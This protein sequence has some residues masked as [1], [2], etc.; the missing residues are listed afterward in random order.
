[1]QNHWKSTWNCA[2]ALS[3]RE[4]EQLERGYHAMPASRPNSD[5]SDLPTFRSSGAV[6]E[7]GEIEYA[8]TAQ[9]R[10]KIRHGGMVV[11][12]WLCQ[13]L[14]LIHSNRRNLMKFVYLIFRT[15]PTSRKLSCFQ[16][17]LTNLDDPNPQSPG[18]TRQRTRTVAPRIGAMPKA[19]PSPTT[20]PG[21]NLKPNISKRFSHRHDYSTFLKQDAGKGRNS[22]FIPFCCHYHKT[23]EV[24]LFKT[25]QVSKM[26]FLTTKTL[27]PFISPKR[28]GLPSSSPY[29]PGMGK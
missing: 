13:Q 4:A 6:I 29:S 11:V 14:N 2:F 19:P 22:E 15:S 9:N 7:D 20:S 26:G 27:G 24:I 28:C 12:L 23:H 16:L 17:R 10:K 8:K 3:F 1:M 18:K 5:R 21:F 25:F